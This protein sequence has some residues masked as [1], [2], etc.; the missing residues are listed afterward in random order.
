MKGP[1]SLE[2]RILSWVQ[3]RQLCGLG[4]APLSTRIF[5]A[6]SVEEGV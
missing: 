1:E 6:T 3:H 4:Q 5:V 2:T